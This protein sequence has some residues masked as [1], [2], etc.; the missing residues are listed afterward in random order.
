MKIL[1]ASSEAVPLV[2]TG[3]LGDVSGSLPVA[4]RQL[5]HDV[6]LVLPAYPDAVAR[7][8]DLESLGTLH[9]PLA[10]APVSLLA[11]LLNG[12]TVPVYL[13]HAPGLFDRPGNPYLGPDGRDWA[14]NALRFAVFCQAATEIAAGR[15]GFGWRAELVHAN[16]WQTGLM[17]ALLLQEPERP[18]TLFT[19]H[20]LSYQGTFDRAT[21]DALDLPPAWW[22]PDALEFWGA[23]SFLK[24]GIALSDLVTTVSPTYAWEIRQPHL[25]CGL[26]GLLNHRAD[27]LYGILNGIDYE[28]WNPASDPA[29]A[30]HYGPE[31][32]RLK[33]RNRTRLQ[34]QMGLEPRRDAM[35][36][37]HVGR[38]VEQK[39][40]DLIL[41]VLPQLM[42]EP[43]TQLVMLG[44]GDRRL[45]AKL[46]EAVASYPGR[47][48][49]H[50]GYDEPLSHLVEAGSDCFLMPSRFEPCGLNQLFSLRY[51]TV[52]VVHKTGGLADTVIDATAGNLKAGK[53]T[54]FVFEH[55]DPNGLWWAI[56]RALALWRAPG[57]GW[58]GLAVTGM[59]QDHS[60][61][62]SAR[63]Y[64][65]LYAIAR[66]YA[67][68]AG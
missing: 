38:L 16:D 23:F 3:G 32:F 33:S 17:A 57:A 65:E 50:I 26:D 66:G 20:N 4:L 56:G 59:R 47:V 51:G 13:V 24:G 44:S 40:V 25:G 21:F 55:A 8:S 52:P 62:A 46:R 60:W 68:G 2:K 36:F 18:A 41:A 19:I 9:V 5:G 37:G 43:D 35:L 12:S 27:R 11:G 64:E 39:G 15:S 30:Q 58:E 54:G 1:F 6:R 49:T 34:Q 67:A 48:A 29:I 61:Q 45:E 7:V 42:A 14:D 31:S 28:L 10:P 63:R 53:A 22:S